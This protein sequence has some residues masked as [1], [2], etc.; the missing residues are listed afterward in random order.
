MIVLTEFLILI[1]SLVRSRS[2]A[3]QLE[4]FERYYEILRLDEAEVRLSSKL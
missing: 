2:A 1:R 3:I 4:Q